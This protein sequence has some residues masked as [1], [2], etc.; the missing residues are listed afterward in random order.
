MESDELMPKNKKEVKID[1]ISGSRSFN[2]LDMQISQSLI[3]AID[4]FDNI[5]Y[6]IVLDYYDDVTLFDLDS[7]PLIVSYYQLKT[8]EDTISITKAIENEWF[9]KL[10][11]QLNRKEVWDVKELG[12][13]TNLPMEFNIKKEDENSTRKVYLKKEQTSFCDLDPKIQERIINN[14]SGKLKIDAEKVDL[15]KLK[16]YMMRFSISDH[17]DFAEKKMSDFLYGKYPK[18]TVDTV[19]CIFKSMVELFTRC[20]EYE[21]LTD[22]ETLDNVRKHKGVERNQFERVI[23]QSIMFTVPDFPQIVQYLAP[24]DKEK[25]NVSLAWATI[26]SDSTQNNPSFSRLFEIIQTKI[27]TNPF[28]GNISVWDYTHNIGEKISFEHPLLCV[29]YSGCYIP[30]LITCL[31]INKSRRIP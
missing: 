19:K 18:I 2:R 21:M 15:T 12:L 11:A 13:I 16:H 7:N 3:M 31:L 22:T 25:A 10:Y 23:D 14:I 26:I 29:P 9:V 27:E 24:S 28:N 20:Q 1:Q 8:S 30:V 5:N 6:L 17:K 4:L